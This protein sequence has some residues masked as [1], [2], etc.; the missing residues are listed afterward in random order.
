MAPSRVS[1]AMVRPIRRAGSRNSGVSSSDSTVICHEML[2]ITA[3]VSTSVTRLPTTPESVSEKA[4]CAPIT[5]L[6]SRLTRAPVRVLVKN[7]TGIRCTWS[8]TA[9]RRSRIRPSPMFDD[10]QRVS[11]PIGLG[12]ATAP[13]TAGSAT[14]D[15]GRPPLPIASTTLPASSG[16]D[17]GDQRADHADPDEP[18]QPGGGAPRSARSGSAAYGSPTPAGRRRLRAPADTGPGGYHFDAHVITEPNNR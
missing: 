13:I 18:A 6:P 14:T 9:V 12:H 2:S 15:A 3:S 5:S 16:V 1:F 17:T 11:S 10:S 7:A 8:N 4:R